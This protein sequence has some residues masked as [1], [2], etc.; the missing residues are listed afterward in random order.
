MLVY[1]SVRITDHWIVTLGREFCKMVR[2]IFIYT[3]EEV[4]KMKPGFKLSAPSSTEAEEGDSRVAAN[5]SQEER[6]A[7]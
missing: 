6:Q 1:N 7:E 4:K 5:F 3:S 2:K